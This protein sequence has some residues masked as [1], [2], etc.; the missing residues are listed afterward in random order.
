MKE[1]AKGEDEKEEEEEEEEEKE[2]EEVL[3]KD[4]PKSPRRP[5]I[6]LSSRP[7]SR[8]SLSKKIV[9]ETPDMSE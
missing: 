9:L 5:P 8:K 7:K 1:V 6:S 4:E 2:K 3:L